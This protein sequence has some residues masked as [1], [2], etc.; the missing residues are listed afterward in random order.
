[1][2]RTRFVAFGFFSDAASS[3][4]ICTIAGAGDGSGEAGACLLN[5]K[6]IMMAYD[7]I[8]D[9]ITESRCLLSCE[10]L[11]CEGLTGFAERSSKWV[12]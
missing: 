9:V 10:G 1:M 2:M 3:G 7:G 8:G 4:L 5:K 12:I 11:T 6:P